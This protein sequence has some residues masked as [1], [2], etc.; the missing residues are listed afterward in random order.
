MPDNRTPEQPR[1]VWDH[2]DCPKCQDSDRNRR[3]FRCHGTLFMLTARGRLAQR[4]YIG[5]CQKAARD[6]IP[7]DQFRHLFYVRYDGDPP[8]WYW[9]TVTNNEFSPADNLSILLVAERAGKE[10]V[11]ADAFVHV[12]QSEESAAE[13]MAI[14]LAYQATLTS[15]GKPIAAWIPRNSKTKRGEHQ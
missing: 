10:V 13:K 7:G 4:R 11:R 8:G 1:P 9:A 6:L 12:R 5:L 2:V 15:E 14:A 3:C